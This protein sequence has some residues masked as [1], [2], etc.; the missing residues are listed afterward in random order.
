[1]PLYLSENF[2][3]T[4]MCHT[5]TGLD[6]TPDSHSA[7]KLYY[8]CQF[9]LQQTRDKHGRLKI[10]SG[11]RSPEVNDK[12]R[13]S[14]ASQHMRGEAADIVPLDAILYDVFKWIALNCTFGQIIIYPDRG[15]IHVSL[16]RLLQENQDAQIC[17]NGIYS[18]WEET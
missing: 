6:N 17:L 5:D 8:L 16:P 15:F 3:L 2:T 7:Q 13:G 10:N 11:Y 14:K 4:E 12:A 9:I 18:K 1:M